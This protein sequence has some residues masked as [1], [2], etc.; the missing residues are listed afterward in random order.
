MG[1]LWKRD[2]AR[3]EDGRVGAVLTS[4]R[5]E[6]LSAGPKPCVSFARSKTY[7]A[8][9][10]RAGPSGAPPTETGPK[11]LGSLDVLLCN[12]PIIFA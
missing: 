4:S 3:K 7:P 9:G 8:S 5:T 11:G 12:A 10:A 1:G 2:H 6:R